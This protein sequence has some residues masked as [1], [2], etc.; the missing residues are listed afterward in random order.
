MNFASI[1]PRPIYQSMSRPVKISPTG[2]MYKIAI[3][4]N[5]N[6][7]NHVQNHEIWMTKEAVQKHFGG[8]KEDPQNYQLMQFAKHIYDHQLLTVQGK[9][10][11]DGILATTDGIAHGET[12]L[13]PH[14]LAHPEVKM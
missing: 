8:M 1:A 14:T 10:R 5:D 12:K 9:T 11:H 6:Q 2:N 4:R 7:G 13:W 3:A